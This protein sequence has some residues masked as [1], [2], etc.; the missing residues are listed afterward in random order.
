MSLKI[1]ALYHKK[2]IAVSKQIKEP[3]KQQ[4]STGSLRHWEE[5]FHQ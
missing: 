3:R 2:R 4:V 1:S 5:E